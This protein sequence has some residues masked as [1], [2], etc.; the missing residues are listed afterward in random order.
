MWLLVVERNISE[1]LNWVSPIKKAINI[2]ATAQLE[3]TQNN[4]KVQILN[5]AVTIWDAKSFV[6]NYNEM[7]YAYLGKDRLLFP[8]DPLH[9][10]KIS[11]EADFL[12]VESIIR[13]LS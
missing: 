9:G 6:A 2:D 13:G 8:I 3:P 11:S 5:W 12:M 10:I 4:K 1:T 7:G